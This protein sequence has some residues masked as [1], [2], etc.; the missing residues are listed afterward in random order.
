MRFVLQ[1]ISGW[2][3][4]EFDSSR[5]FEAEIRGGPPFRVILT[6]RD[7]SVAAFIQRVELTVSSRPG[8]LESVEIVESPENSTKIEFRN[9]EINV[10]FPEK[11]F[12]EVQ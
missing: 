5:H 12:R 7:P 11:L 1:D 4:G 3:S 10:P 6:P 8:V 9:T 2:V